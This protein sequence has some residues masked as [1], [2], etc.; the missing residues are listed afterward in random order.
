VGFPV[1]VEPEDGDGA[2]GEDD[3]GDGAPD[4]E[5]PDGDSDDGAVEDG[6]C[7]DGDCDPL[8]EGDEDGDRD[9][10]GLGPPEAGGQPGEPGV[11]PDVGGHGI[12][13]V[14]GCGSAGGPACWSRPPVSSPR[15][16]WNQSSWRGS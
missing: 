15:W 16:R 9:A 4:G 10:D 3:S 5:P 8:D 14:Q 6:D 2:P 12:G 13:V 7:D 11:A 1:D